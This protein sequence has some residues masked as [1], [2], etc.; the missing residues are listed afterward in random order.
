MVFLVKT[1]L[2]GT[3]VPGFPT[4]I[5][6]VMF[7]AGVQLISLGVI[8]EYLGRMYEEIK[9]RPLFLVAEE[10]GIERERP[11]VDAA[12]AARAA[13]GMTA[14]PQPAGAPIARA[15]SAARPSMIILCADDYAMTEGISRAIGELAAAQRLSATSVMVTSPH[16]PATAPR[17]R[18]HRGHLSIGLHLN[19]TLGRPARADA[20][21]G[22]GRH[23]C[24][25][26]RRPRCPGLARPPRSASE[27][28]AEIERQLDRFETGLQ[29][30]ARPHRRAPARACAA[31]RAS[32]RC[33]EAVQRRYP[34]TAAADPRSRR[35]G[36]PPSP[37]GAWR[38]RR[39]CRSRRWRSASRAR[40]DGR[41]L[42]VND[43]F[44][45][46]S[47]FDVRSSLR[48]RAAA[49]AAQPGR[50]HLVM[51]HPGHPDAELAAPRSRGR[52]AAHGVRGAD[53]R[54]G[55]CRSASGGPRAAPTG[56]PIAWPRLRD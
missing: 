21:A 9:G 44:A 55:A 23:A 28:R 32:A 33:C 53:A 36:S 15:G 27:I 31:G 46:F 17:L 39:P 4:L 26:L 54:S 49:R 29:L 19:L 47:D 52:A 48:R 5:I 35:T 22:A 8:G 2:Y 7:F 3:D 10:L 50:R 1:L 11:R 18:A 42:P 25:A 14:L 34:A 45:G 43:S 51:C 13:R 20:A 24:R 38:C 16:W 12:D 6:S 40:R 30:P 41:G 56:P 37:R